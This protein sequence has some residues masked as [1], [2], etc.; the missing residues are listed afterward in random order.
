MS[1]ASA[2]SPKQPHAETRAE[3]LASTITHGIGLALSVAGV[4]VMVALAA[5]RGGAIHVVTVSLF[6]VAMLG[7]YLSSTLYHAC[8]G[9]RF[10]HPLKVLDHTAIYALIAGTYTPFL[11]VLIRGGWGWSLFGV[12]WG[13]TVAGC[14]FKV[15][16]VHRFEVVSTAVYVAMGWMGLIALGPFL[17]H[18]P[19]GVLWW[20]L[21]GGLA[22][23]AGVAFYLW[24][25]LPFNHAIWHL[26]VM[27]GTACH[28]F[29]VLLYVVP[30]GA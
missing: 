29:A 2:I 24:D 3:D 26:F 22:Y 1:Q 5:L 15:F 7:V 14:A 23:T 21:A 13:L 9:T 10:E 4:S 28:F 25:G 20:I 27:G 11:L 30:G 12:L 6:G 19:A 16:F 18:L 8:R 17:T